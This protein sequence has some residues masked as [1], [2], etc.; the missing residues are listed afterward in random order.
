MMKEKSA[1]RIQVIQIRGNQRK[2]AGLY[3][4]LL[5]ES[6]KQLPLF[7]S[8]KK[9]SCIYFKYDAPSQEVIQVKTDKSICPFFPLD[10]LTKAVWL[11]IKK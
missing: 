7:Y 5:H 1:I 3:W 9:K 8:F 10:N 6:V 2:I 4:T 11:V